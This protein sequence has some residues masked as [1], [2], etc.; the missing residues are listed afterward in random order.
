MCQAIFYKSKP[1]ADLDNFSK[2]HKE[3]TMQELNVT[4]NSKYKA[5][6]FNFIFGKP[7]NKK[8]TLSLYNAVN[9]S[10]YINEDDVEM[11][12]IQNV[13]YLGMHN[14]TSFLISDTM[15]VY[16]QQ[17]TYNPNMPLRQMQY[18][19]NLYDSYIAKYKKNKYGSKLIMLPAPKLVVFYNGKTEKEDE[20]FLKLSDSFPPEYKDEPDI[21]VKVRML[22]INYGHNRKLLNECK[23]LYEYSWFIDKIRENCKSIDITEAVSKAINEMPGT[24]VIKTFLENN[25][26]EV[27]GMLDTEYNEAE[28]MELFKEEGREEGKVEAMHNLIK[29][30]GITAE[31]AMAAIGIPENE[32]SAYIKLLK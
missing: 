4:V 24:Y 27:T 28:A 31:Q 12:T 8:W 16:E 7:E 18:V 32:Y 2:Q 11:T 23:P 5:R 30:L 19:G 26:E 15:N 1:Y 13:L 29:N 17:S 3:K 21:E 20:R 9:H 25:R 6:L 10:S 14:D 22:N